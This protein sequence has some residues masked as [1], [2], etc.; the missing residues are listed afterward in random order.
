[1]SGTSAASPAP[2]SVPASIPIAAPVA[3]RNPPSAAPVQAPPP[4]HLSGPIPKS[5]RHPMPAP[6]F[7]SLFH[8]RRRPG[9]RSPLSVR[10][11]CQRQR[12]AN[13]RWRRAQRLHH[14]RP[15]R[16]PELRYGS[17]QFREDAKRKQHHLPHPHSRLRRRN[18]RK[19]SPT[20]PSSPIWPRTLNSRTSWASPAIPITAAM[21]APSRALAGKLKISRSRCSPA[22]PITSKS[23]SPMSSSR[24]N[25]A[26]LRPR[27]CTT[28]LPK[29]KPT[30]PT[31]AH[32]FSATLSPSPTSCASYRPPFL[33]LM[34]FPGNPT[35]Q[36]I[37]AG[38]AVFNQVH[39]NMCH[40][41]SLQTGPSN[42]TPGLSNQPAASFLR[43]ARSPHGHRTCRQCRARRRWPRRIP[44][45]SALGSRPTRLLPARWPRHPG[46]WR[47]AQAI[48]AHS[49]RGSEANQ[50]ISLF[51]QL[52]PQEKQQLLNFLRSL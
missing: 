20:P 25:A 11:N 13:S 33:P 39:C 26:I 19:Y 31:P 47:L 52:P 34:E 8:L 4:I 21:T 10:S 48:Q 41:P 22:K 16:R 12:H 9:A 3:T 6:Q 29:T 50:V 27:A 23:A 15:L 5:R 17:A 18:D 28:P 30:T 38:Q 32:R 43:F 45:R 14:R 49:S 7:H 24:P 2:A 51:N 42:M 36:S 46:K 40:T 44:H 37:Q 35:P 1:M